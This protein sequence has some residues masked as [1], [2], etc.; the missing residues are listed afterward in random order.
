MRLMIK[1]GK[2]WI[3]RSDIY[4]FSKYLGIQSKDFF[5]FCKQYNEWMNTGFYPDM[6][7]ELVWKND[8][9]I[10]QGWIDTS[11]IVGLKTCRIAF[12][13]CAFTLLLL[14]R[15]E[16]LQWNSTRYILLLIKLMLSITS[17]SYFNNYKL[18]SG[19]WNDVLCRI[20]VFCFV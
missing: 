2:K 11:W 9:C 18:S 19:V 10:V 14:A 12:H 7:Y 20:P 17:V 3:I 16:D 6:V 5:G 8:E 4:W 1:W 15:A 13:H